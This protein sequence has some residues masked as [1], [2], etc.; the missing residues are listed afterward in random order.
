M[1]QAALPSPTTAITSRPAHPA[2]LPG[3]RADPSRC[4]RPC[5]PGSSCPAGS[6]RGSAAASP[7]TTSNRRRSRWPGWSRRRSRSSVERRRWASRHAPCPTLPASAARAVAFSR[8]IS[9]ARR[10]AVSRLR[11][12]DVMALSSARVQ[13]GQRGLDVALQTA[14]GR[15]SSCRSPRDRRRCGRS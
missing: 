9:S 11:G 3:R 8:P 12:P 10:R 5:G 14:V 15:D 6:D 2:S 4:S 13:L 1:D 7:T